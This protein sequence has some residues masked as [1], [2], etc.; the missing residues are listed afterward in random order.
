MPG[1]V[2]RET[3]EMKLQLSDCTPEQILVL[4]HIVSGIF[5]LEQIEDVFDVIEH[6][7]AA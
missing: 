2:R 1:V 7:S 6:R 4:N 5:V 3:T